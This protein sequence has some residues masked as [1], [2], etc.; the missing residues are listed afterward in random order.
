MW[1]ELY[2][3]Q[4][5]WQDCAT[6]YGMSYEKYPTLEEFISLEGTFSHDDFPLRIASDTNFEELYAACP[7]SPVGGFGAWN[8]GDPIQPAP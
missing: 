6:Q 8:P 5:A 4:L 2:A 1:E 3:Y 7:P